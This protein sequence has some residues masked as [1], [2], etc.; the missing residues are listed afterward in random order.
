MTVQVVKLG[1]QAMLKKLRPLILKRFD[2]DEWKMVKEEATGP[3]ARDRIERYAADNFDPDWEKQL[4]EKG[5]ENYFKT[6][7]K[8]VGGKISKR[9]K[10]VRYAKTGGQVGSGSSFVASLY[11]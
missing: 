11:K 3:G 5:V 9:K 2:K 4:K 6:E 7:S 1:V 8:S 10:A